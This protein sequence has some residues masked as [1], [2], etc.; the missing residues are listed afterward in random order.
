MKRVAKVYKKVISILADIICISFI[1]DI[2]NYAIKENNIITFLDDFFNDISNICL[3]IM[4]IASV[5]ITICDI[6]DIIRKQKFIGVLDYL[7]VSMAISGFLVMLSFSNNGKINYEFVIGY[8]T[9]LILLL[10]I[11]NFLLKY[12]LKHG[13]NL[14]I[15][16]MIKKYIYLFNDESQVTSLSDYDNQIGKNI[17]IN[18]RKCRE[19]DLTF[20][21]ELREDGFKW[22]LKNLIGWDETQQKQI[23]LNEMAEHLDDMKIIQYEGK[24]VGLFTFYIDSNGDG[25]I[26]MLAI[27]PKYRNQGIGSEILDYLISTYPNTRLYLRTYKQNPA[28]KLYMRFGFVIYDE[29]EDYWWMERVE[30]TEVN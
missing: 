2:L 13:Y 14:G 18:F 26:D 1:L 21:Y 16:D 23:I 9:L 17:N 22:Y 10:G 20:I 4:V 29:T 5:I 24:D 28:R 25:F 15:K 30:K 11:V 3:I 7:L 27:S 6:V 8:T 12:G 19:R